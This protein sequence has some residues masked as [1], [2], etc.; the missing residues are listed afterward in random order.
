[1]R[2]YAEVAKI[3]LKEQLNWRA[4]VAFNMMFTVTK[5]LFAYL[6]WGAIFNGR[7]TVS[8]FTFHSMLS[9]YTISSFLSQLEMSD[10]ISDELNTQIRNGTFSKYLVLPI[11]VEGYFTAKGMGMVAFYLFFDLAAAFVWVVLF[12]IQ[13]VF[14]REWMVLLCAA[15]L[16]VLGLLFMVQLNF[17][18]GILTFHYPDIQTFLMIKNNM[19]EL[20][21]GSIVPLVLFPE[22]VIHGMKL[23]PF[24]YVTYLPSMLLTGRCHDEAVPGIFIL[25]VWCI[26]IQ[27]LI[28]FTWRKYCRTYDGVGI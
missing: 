19:M 8:G 11:Q 16:I 5:V 26:G 10:R 18:L 21:T 7:E 25:L 20:L 12:G 28:S 2:K 24:Y 17:Y 27:V 4:D 6:L 22:A 1:M 14:T 9:Y 3:T 15:I 13:L 23:L